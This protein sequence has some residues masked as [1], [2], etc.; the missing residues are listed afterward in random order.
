[1]PKPVGSFDLKAFLAQVEQ[2]VVKLG[3]LAAP[4][5]SWLLLL[6][7]TLSGDTSMQTAPGLKCGPDGCS[8]CAEAVDCTVHC[9]CHALASA[10]QAK[11]CLECQDGAGGKT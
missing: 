6:L 4:A 3:P 7:K 5:G 8:D 10:L 1:M 2:W 9:L 11:Y